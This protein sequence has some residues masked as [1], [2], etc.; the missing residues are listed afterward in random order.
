MLWEGKKTVLLSSGC[1]QALWSAVCIPCPLYVWTTSQLQKLN[2]FATLLGD[3]AACHHMR[4]ALLPNVGRLVHSV[5]NVPCKLLSTDDCLALTL[6]TNSVTERLS[7]S[8]H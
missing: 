2:F 1:L 5:R 3:L 7:K 4:K 6:V 8:Q